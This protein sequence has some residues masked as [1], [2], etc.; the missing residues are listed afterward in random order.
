MIIGNSGNNEYEHRNR[1]I[2]TQILINL[3]IEV[4]SDLKE[5]LFYVFKTF[6]ELFRIRGQ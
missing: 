6:L 4:E 2:I 1:K 3:W 5:V